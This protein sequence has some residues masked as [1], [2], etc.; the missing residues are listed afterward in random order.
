M[1]YH[2]TVETFAKTVR[3]PRDLYERLRL[4]A[5]AHRVSQASII[6][7]AVRRELDRLER[8]LK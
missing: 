3:L 6:T 8:K 4:V 7:E 5:F 2:D 1:R